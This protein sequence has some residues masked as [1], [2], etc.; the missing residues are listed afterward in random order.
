MEL[1]EGEVA[2][3]AC[4]AAGAPSLEA[5]LDDGHLRRPDYAHQKA[6]APDIKPAN[7]FRRCRAR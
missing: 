7:L 2:R 3:R 4:P 5:T 6:I 1:I